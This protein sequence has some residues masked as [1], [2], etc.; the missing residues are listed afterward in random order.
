MVYYC[1][2]FELVRASTI[3]VSLQLTRP[4]LSFSHTVF[5][6]V[7]STRAPIKPPAS[8]VIVVV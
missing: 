2:L 6:L 8:Y 4:L 3:Q 1:F 7:Q 5:A